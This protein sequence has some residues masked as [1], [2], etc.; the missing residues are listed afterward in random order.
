VLKVDWPFEFPGAYWLD[1]QE[2]NAVQDVLKNGSLFR[3]YGLGTPKHVDAFEAL[4]REYF[5][6]PYALAINSGT[7]ALNAAMS[8]LKIGPGCEVII[9]SF[10]WV[11]TV[12]S[13]VQQNAIPVLCEVDETL[14]MD[15]RDLEKKITSRTKLIVPIHMIGAPCD[16]DAIMAIANRHGIPVLE[17]TAQCIGGTYRGRPLGS[18]GSIGVFSFQL[19]KNITCGEGGLLVTDDEQLFHRAFSSHDMGMIRVNGRLAMPGPEAVAWGA[20]RRMPELCGAVANVQM[21]KLD[22]ILDAM[23][24]SKRRTRRTGE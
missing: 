22:Q 9:P 3:Y 14:C 4:A 8:A 16:M 13:V 1:E 24:A 2:E 10:L 6:K 23:R 7:G 5:N 12:A 21:Q 15:P 19:N 11:A 20:G 17:D 18:I